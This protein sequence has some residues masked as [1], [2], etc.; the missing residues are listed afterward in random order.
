LFEAAT[1]DDGIHLLLDV[2]A[3]QARAESLG[4]TLPAQALFELV[5]SA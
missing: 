1:I 3:L 5:A 2:D 4:L